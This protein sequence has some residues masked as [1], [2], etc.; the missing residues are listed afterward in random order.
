MDNAAKEA[1]EILTKDRRETG[2]FFMGYPID[3]YEDKTFYGIMVRQGRTR[4]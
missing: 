4:D 1:V 2:F 3:S